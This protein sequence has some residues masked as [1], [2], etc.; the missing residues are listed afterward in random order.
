MHSTI[1]VFIWNM[2][3]LWALKSWERNKTNEING[4]HK[5]STRTDNPVHKPGKETKGRKYE[6]QKTE[7][8]KKLGGDL[9]WNDHPSRRS[10]IVNGHWFRSMSQQH[11]SH[12]CPLRQC[13]H[14]GVMGR[15]LG[16]REDMGQIFNSLLLNISCEGVRKRVAKRKSWNWWS[17]I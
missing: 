4:I 9:G 14:V 1:K 12:R 2:L 5:E 17:K 11:E 15:E 3:A 7:S 13:N 10:V 6:N 8:A 16:R